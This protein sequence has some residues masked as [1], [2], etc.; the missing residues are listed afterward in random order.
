MLAMLLCFGAVAAALIAA[1]GTWR[2]WDFRISDHTDTE[3]DI[4]T[5]ARFHPLEFVY[6][7]PIMLVVVLAFGIP[8]LAVI[9]F[10]LVRQYGVAALGPHP[11]GA[12]P[13]RAAP[14]A[15]RRWSRSRR[16]AP[17]RPP[18][19]PFRRATR[20]RRVAL[21]VVPARRRTARAMRHI[22]SAQL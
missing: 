21:Q 9:V 2:A 17:P 6:S 16:R 7:T 22:I 14:G 4:S 19:A 11:P 10:E 15:R 12:H 8:P 1:F 5:T 18:P 3:I 13:R 20:R